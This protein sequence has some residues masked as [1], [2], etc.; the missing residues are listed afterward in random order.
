MKYRVLGR[1]GPK[2]SVI[3]LG[4]TAFM[5]I[6]G[7]RDP[8]AVADTLRLGLDSGINLVDTAPSY[9]NGFAETMLGTVLRGR[10]HEV[11]LTTKVGCYAPEEFDFS[12]QRIRSGLEDS[13]RRLE[14]DHVDILLAH[15]IEYADPRHVTT[16]VLPLLE[17]LKAEGKARAVGVSGLPLSVLDTAV[18][19]AELDVVLSYCR[20][21]VHDTSLTAAARRWRERG[22][23]TVL[24]SAVAMGLLTQAGP[25][26]WH[27]APSELRAAAARAAALCAERGADLAT[28]TI[29]FAFA[30]DALGSVL[31]GTAD[32]DHLRA[33]IRALDT[34]PDPQLLADVRSVFA[35]VAN[36]TWPSGNG[37]WP[38]DGS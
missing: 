35:G 3:G 14:T 19:A 21:G 13:L 28:L 31:T 38:D 22:T 8:G 32:G 2:V 4:T 27:P 1:G 36:P 11:V 15:D 29:Q 12:E 16:V 9:G 18:S 5:G 34:A 6:F 37:L 33:M 24:G 26:R 10:R 17:K 25:P 30:N 20:Y 7:R 23:G